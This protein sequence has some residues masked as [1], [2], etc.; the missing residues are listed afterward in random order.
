MGAEGVPEIAAGLIIFILV[1]ATVVN[2]FAMMW[3]AGYMDVYDASFG[4]CFLTALFTMIVQSI[5]SL[6]IHGGVIGWIAGAVVSTTIIKFM[7][8]IEWGR[9]FM[10]HI[11]MTIVLFALGVA[12]VVVSCMC[13]GAASTAL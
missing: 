13:I 9:A 10:L 11:M 12:F 4:R 3:A 5:V 8:D 1:I 7:L 6:V 2:T